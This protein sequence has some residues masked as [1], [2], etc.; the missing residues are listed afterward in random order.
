[1]AGLSI[2]SVQADV[3]S[4]GVNRD[5]TMNQFCIDPRA[6]V[7]WAPPTN[8]PEGGQ[9]PPYTDRD[10]IPTST[11]VRI[12]RRL[13][14][15][16]VALL[17]ANGPIALAADSPTTLP[18]Q[19]D[20]PNLINQLDADDFATRESAQAKLIDAG[21]AA[22]D[23]LVQASKNGSPE[24]RL[25]A[26][27]ILR[28]LT[29][30][31]M[32]E[33]APVGIAPDAGD[34]VSVG[35]DGKTVDV[36]SGGRSIHIEQGADGIHMTVSGFIDGKPATQKFDA[37]DPDALKAKSA[38]AYALWD[39]WHARDGAVTVVQGNG[40]LI[41]VRGGLLNLP[42]GMIPR[43]PDPADDF[44]K[45]T[46]DAIAEMEKKHFS[47]EQKGQVLGQIQKV[48]IA[49]QAAGTL[50]PDN[51]KAQEEFL[52]DSD[53]L[54]KQ[55]AAEG[56]PDPGTTLP[57]PASSRL[58]VSISNAADLGAGNGIVINSVQPDSRAQRLGLAAGDVIET[59]NGKAVTTTAELRGMVMANPRVSLTVIRNGQEMKL[60]ETAPQTMPTAG[61]DAVSH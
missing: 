24:Q 39:Q 22:K 15:A 12:T 10:R 18:S 2:Q 53:D 11:P 50:G 9:C 32:P 7:G 4:R 40:A 25:R 38:E 55:L 6:Q 16:F 51:F 31:Q 48:R 14:T 26:A 41:V 49:E 61:A 5:N 29:T 58:G 54:R 44:S 17:I 27:E 36:T 57:P 59:I 21:P 45:L 19:S 34:S 46:G 47:E 23:A 8:S 28:R 37:A 56:L 33:A 20:I 52:K 42:N 60:E 35:V 30:P 3:T 13:I 1:M 43:P